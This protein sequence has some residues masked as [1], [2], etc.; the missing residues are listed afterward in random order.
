[1]RIF[2]FS[3][4][5]ELLHQ[6]AETII[7]KVSLADELVIKAKNRLQEIDVLLRHLDNLTKKGVYVITK[8]DKDFPLFLKHKSKD[9]SSLY[10]YHSGTT[11]N[12]IRGIR[13]SGLAHVDADE[14]NVIAK[15]I[16]KAKSEDKPYVSICEKGVDLVGLEQALKNDVN[17]VLIVYR[18]FYQLLDKYRE[19]VKNKKMVIISQFEPETQ[20]DPTNE[21]VSDALSSRFCEFRIILS[22]K[23]NSGLT[24]FNAIQNL[25][26]KWTRIFVVNTKCPGNQ[27]LLTYD[28]VNLNLSDC[29]SDFSFEY[30]YEKNRKLAV[31]NLEE[32]IQLSIFD[33][34]PGGVE[35]ESIT[36]I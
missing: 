26:Y 10:L 1:M 9:K 29:Y 34:I 35:D 8:Y 3:S 27:K 20:Y 25:T 33:F 23:L 18:D 36:T 19:I 15:V 32:F 2:G 30:L 5:S 13:I 22:C 17:V 21:I 14:H 16:K 12:L 6:D 31:V 7:K 4:I 28:Y 11:S 24:W